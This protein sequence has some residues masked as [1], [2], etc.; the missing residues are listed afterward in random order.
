VDAFREVVGKVVEAVL[1]T[2]R[3]EAGELSELLLLPREEIERALEF[4]SLSGR[5]ELDEED[6]V[7]AVLRALELGIDGKVLARYL[8]W[9]EFEKL[10]AKVFD[11]IGYETIWNLVLSAGK[12]RVQIDLI[13]YR[14]NLL[15][16]IDCKHWKIPPPPSAEMRIVE[17]QERRL[18]LL[19]EILESFREQSSTE[20]YAVPLVLSLYQPSKKI[21]NGHLFSSISNLR[22]LIEYVESA[23]FQVRHVKIPIPGAN[24]LPDLLRRKPELGKGSFLK[25]G[26]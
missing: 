21:V 15:L 22:G 17:G 11:R 2:S 19:K 25:S 18:E 8:G 12:K 4:L 7:E 26:K 13:A 14:G 1:K 9:R 16:V 23:Y 6:K 5:G 20:V 24:R 3:L 10:A